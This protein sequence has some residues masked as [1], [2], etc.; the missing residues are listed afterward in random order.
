VTAL[1][2]VWAF[3]SRHSNGY[4]HAKQRVQHNIV[5]TAMTDMTEEGNQ[6]HHRGSPQMTYIIL[7]LANYHVDVA[8]NNSVTIFIFCVEFHTRYPYLLS[9]VSLFVTNISFRIF[10]I[11]LMQ[12]E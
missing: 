9:S 5:T 2:G 4:L 8:K 11:T 1:H 12:L 7:I 6:S 3:Q 10:H